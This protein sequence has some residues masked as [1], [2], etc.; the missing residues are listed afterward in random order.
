MDAMTGKTDV[1]EV[2]D[3]ERAPTLTDDTRLHLGIALRSVYE[4]L[5]ETQPIPNAQVDLLLRLRH[6]E[7]DLR[8]VG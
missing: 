8:R 7:R 1:W 6:K 2:P 4:D 3:S 5:C